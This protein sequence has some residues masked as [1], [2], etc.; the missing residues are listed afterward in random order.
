MD[1]KRLLIV[2]LTLFSIRTARA[3]SCTTL[4]QTPVTAFPVCGT[5][6]FKQDN[7]PTCT[8]GNIPLDCHDGAQYSD[9]N[10]FWYKFT[11]FA[12]GTLGF[13]ITP[14]TSSDDYDWQLFDVTGHDPSEVYT[15]TALFV[16]GNWSSNPA[17]TG[18][19]ANGNGNINC[20]GPTYSNK[21]I[22]PTLIVGHQ[23]LL[24]VS[25]FT[26]SQ[27][28]YSLSFG[29]GTASITDSVPPGL[30]SIR[31]ICDGSR[32]EVVLNKKMKCSSLAAD[33]SDFALSPS[34]AQVV[35][36]SGNNCAGG[37]DMDTL[38]LTL[39]GPLP[40]GNY[41][42]SATNGSDGNTLLDN[43]GN[44]VPV[45]SSLTFQLA[46]L[47]PTYLDSITPPACAPSSL[48]LVFQKKILCSS[49]AANG[50][51]FKVTGPSTVQVTGAAGQCDANGETYTILLQL[52]GPIVTGGNYQVLLAPGTDG[53]TIIDECGISTPPTG[54]TL[55]FTLKDTVSAVFN[56]KILY[57]CKNDTI[58][59]GYPDKNGVNQ[60]QWV[61]DGTDTSRVQ[62]PPMHIYSIISDT[63][64]SAK[65][66]Q[67]IVSNGFCSDT[68]SVVISLDNAIRARFEAPNILCPK[69]AAIFKNNSTGLINTYTWDFGDGTGSTDSLPPDH[70][71]PVTGVEK[72]Y[73]VM[74]IV[75]N[76]SGCY[77]TAVQQIDVL[78]SCYIAVPSAFTP[79]GDGLN[80]YLYPLNAYKAD[81]MEFKVFNRFGQIVFQTSDWTSKW[82]GTV[83]GHPQPAG[84]FVWFLSYTDRDSGKKIFLKGTSILIR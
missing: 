59:V 53:N 23:Y 79:N 68:A 26:N 11:C 18:T 48:E 17:G 34:I 67:L 42:L 40:A 71:F 54:P 24:L 50:S 70:L 63:T 41:T 39:N 75:G 29:G 3:Q 60:W 19:T 49:I 47:Q 28:G 62:A 77:D 12:G 61:F 2:G 58:V 5:S 32:I 83:N 22:M 84:T 80:D 72:K 38:T 36:A 57:G 74:L 73:P 35:S 14:N 81:N 66:I 13:L 69:D 27:S 51:D 82:D 44:Q 43:C 21:N 64:I 37:F 46:A 52:A 16:S 10:P 31:P 78:R 20:A 45:G 15:N 30:K 25:H 6:V 33:G 76:S 7:V 55:P 65:T 9:K 1:V 56:D 4:G 8:N